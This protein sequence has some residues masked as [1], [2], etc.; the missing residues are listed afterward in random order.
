MVHVLNT[1]GQTRVLRTIII[2]MVWHTP[3]HRVLFQSESCDVPVTY[4]I[5]RTR[6]V[7][8]YVR[9]RVQVVT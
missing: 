2:I 8:T 1:N 6:V 5:V 7:R 9:T 4:I 3:I